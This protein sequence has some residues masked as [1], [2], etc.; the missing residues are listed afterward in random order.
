MAFKKSSRPPSQLTGDS[1]DVKSLFY[2]PFHGVSSV[3]VLYVF[4]NVSDYK[5]V[6]SCCQPTSF[7][8]VLRVQHWRVKK[9]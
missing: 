7:W 3:W 1:L 5:K 6:L 9:E 2:F 4:L 8:D